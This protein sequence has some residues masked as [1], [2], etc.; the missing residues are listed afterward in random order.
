MQL[1][2]SKEG[3][4]YIVL[5]IE[6]DRSTRQFLLVNGFFIGAKL[7]VNSNDKLRNLL[8]ISVGGRTVAMRR[9]G[10]QKIEVA[11]LEN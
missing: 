7:K 2:D 3:N 6:Q 8:N 9:S 5:D 4:S 11:K 1:V 10:A